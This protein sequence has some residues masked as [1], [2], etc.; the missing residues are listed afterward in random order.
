MLNL[1]ISKGAFSFVQFFLQM[2]VIQIV[3]RMGF[4]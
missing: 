4:V 1:H 3:V 2:R